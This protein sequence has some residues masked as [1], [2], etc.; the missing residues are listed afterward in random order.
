MFS[1][2]NDEV[3]TLVQVGYLMNSDGESIVA[4]FFLSYTNLRRLFMSFQ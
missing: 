2:N 3:L 4:V 1:V